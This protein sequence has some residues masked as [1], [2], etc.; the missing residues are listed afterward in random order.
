MSFPTAT[1][2]K[3]VDAGAG[4]GYFMAPFGNQPDETEIGSKLVCPCVNYS[5]KQ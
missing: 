5:L 3:E 2:N 1:A 4:I